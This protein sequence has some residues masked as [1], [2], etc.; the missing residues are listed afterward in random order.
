[1]F[2]IH[3]ETTVLVSK[4]ALIASSVYKEYVKPAA[5]AGGCTDIERPNINV[6]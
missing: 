1:V 2:T 3:L 6:V 5:W 4:D